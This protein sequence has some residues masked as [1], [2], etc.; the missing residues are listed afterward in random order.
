M[1]RKLC[2]FVRN[3]SPCSQVAL[4]S[5]RWQLSFPAKQLNRNRCSSDTLRTKSNLE[6]VRMVLSIRVY[7]MNGAIHARSRDQEPSPHVQG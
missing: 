1:T 2:C 5:A 3:I 4:P 6:Q 7:A